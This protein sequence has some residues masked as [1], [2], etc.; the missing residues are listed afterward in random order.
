MHSDHL[1]TSNKFSA[2]TGWKKNR[3]IAC[4]P[5]NGVYFY[6]LRNQYS[7]WMNE[8]CIA[9]QRRDQFGNFRPSSNLAA[10][11][12]FLSLVNVWYFTIVTA[13]TTDTWGWS[14]EQGRE[15]GMGHAN[16]ARH[17]AQ[18]QIRNRLA[19][20]TKKIIK[21]C[22]RGRLWRPLFTVFGK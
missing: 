16:N 5:R 13:C 12:G 18:S 3:C 17:E 2:K 15:Y 10:V 14:R 8:F 4:S 9:S 21:N 11:L 7:Q 22:D 6:I 20:W 1:K 19:R